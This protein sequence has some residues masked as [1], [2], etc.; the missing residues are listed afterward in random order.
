M[1]HGTAG[2]DRGREVGGFVLASS[3]RRRQEL[4]DPMREGE[5]V[6][7]GRERQTLKE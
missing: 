2:E 4:E 1:G 7:R 6:S 5:E 3:R